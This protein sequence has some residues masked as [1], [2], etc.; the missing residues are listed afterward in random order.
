MS[1]NYID[2]LPEEMFLNI[3]SYVGESK[4]ACGHKVNYDL[5]NSLAVSKKWNETL[6]SSAS[7]VKR[8]PFRFE[9]PLH[10]EQ[11]KFVLSIQ[12]NF[13]NLIIDFISPK[14]V[15]DISHILEHGADVRE[16]RIVDCNFDDPIYLKLIFESM[17]L[18]E[19]IHLNGILIKSDIEITPIYFQKLLKLEIIE[20]ST[21]VMHFFTGAESKITHFSLNLKREDQL[22]H[23]IPVLKFL[24]K[25]TKLQDFSSLGNGF[26]YNNVEEF[27]KCQY[28]LK[29]LSFRRTIKHR[30]LECYFPTD[31][32]EINMLDFLKTQAESVEQ[33]TLFKT[34]SIPI[35]KCIFMNFINLKS[36]HFQMD[37]FPVENTAPIFR[38]SP[39]HSVKDLVISGNL[40]YDA[41]KGIFSV[42]PNV[43]KLVV[44]NSS[45]VDSSVML[46]MSTML[47]KVDS[48]HLSKVDDSM[49]EKECKFDALKTLQIHQI[50][51]LSHIGLTTLT[52]CFPSIETLSIKLMDS[53]FNLIFDII[54]RNLINLKVLKLGR[55]FYPTLKVAEVISSNCHN[56][57][58]LKIADYFAND[59]EITCYSMQLMNF[60]RKKA[61]CYSCHSYTLSKDSYTVADRIDFSN[62]IDHSKIM[63]VAFN[64]SKLSLKSEFAM[65]NILVN[66]NYNDEK[67]EQSYD[68]LI[69]DSEWCA[70][71]AIKE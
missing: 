49:F 40:N 61:N 57:R 5:M 15:E 60:C 17:P 56:L 13:Q 39:I 9:G 33:L 2:M 66:G 14:T 25:Q 41:C 64:L 10:S 48:L 12:R 62:H 29:K 4:S 36:I 38:C 19:K 65:D 22:E 20:S 50:K 69:N 46:L 37:V 71:A 59:N 43:Q 53:Q 31:L 1:L 21:K 47:L 27:E 6:L 26:A 18:L 8:L 3:F 55:G 30:M 51:N 7:I 23:L 52:K 58:V 67:N 44:D 16:L 32:N 42:F 28:G 34:F 70:W 68:N 11:I 54:A 63:L 45:P 24:S 35:Y